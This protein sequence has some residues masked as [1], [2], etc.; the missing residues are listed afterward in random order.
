[1]QAELPETWVQVLTLPQTESI[2]Q[3]T[4][5]SLL[6]QPLLYPV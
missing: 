4:Q 1:M 5:H 2:T 6:C 3:D